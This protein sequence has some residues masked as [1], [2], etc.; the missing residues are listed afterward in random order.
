MNPASALLAAAPLDWERLC[1]DA[2][3]PRSTRENRRIRPSGGGPD[4]LQTLA[5]AKWG[6]GVDFLFGPSGRIGV[7]GTFDLDDADSHPWDGGN[8]RAMFL[9]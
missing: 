9:F 6:L 7:Y 8:L 4:D 2:S 3:G 5:E 1:D